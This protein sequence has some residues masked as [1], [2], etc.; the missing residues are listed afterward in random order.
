METPANFCTPQ[1]LADT[2]A[3][4]AALAPE[5]FHLDVLERPAVE[6]LGMGLYLGVAQVSGQR[7][8]WGLCGALMRGAP[9]AHP[10]AN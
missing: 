3:R 2:A 9:A 8:G 4:I 6:K 10:E 7:Q 5:R 1:Y